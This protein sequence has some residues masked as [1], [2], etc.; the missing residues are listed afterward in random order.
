MTTVI[1]LKN[2]QS[3]DTYIGR[4]NKYY[5]LPQS[6][7]A[8]IF[9][10]GKDGSRE[11][12]IEKYRLWINSRPDLLV[13]LHELKGKV[14]S[15]YC[16]PLSCHGDVLIDLAESKWQK[17]W[18]SNMLPFD[19]PLIYQGISYK[20][21][22]NF[23]QAMKMPKTRLDLRAEIAAL[24]PYKSKTE[25]RNKIKYPWD[26]EWNK[27]KSLK[28]MRYALDWKFQPGTEWHRKL[29]IT[30]E[31]G[32]DLVE[33]NTWNDLFWGKDLKTRE[34]ENHLGK[35]LMEIRDGK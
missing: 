14:L 8:N 15:C 12:V 2:G 34:G 24:S 5:G 31:L 18:F 29:M 22:E 35:I 26:S 6:K 4:S 3:F 11:E 7:W 23:Y 13:C 21:S 20:T 17:N 32:L 30:K 16:K 25:I 27:E 33:W 1:N 9:E 10:I 28:V 19:A